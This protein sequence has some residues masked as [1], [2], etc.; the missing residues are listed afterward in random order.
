MVE[1]GISSVR[2]YRERIGRCLSFIQEH[3][4]GELR[5]EDL[6]E[7]ASFSKFH[8]HRVFTAIVGETPAD[9]V[10]RLRLERAANFLATRPSLSI[11]EVAMECGFSSSSVFAREFGRAYG[12]TPSRYRQVGRMPR[13]PGGRGVSN[14]PSGDLAREKGLGDEG[15]VFT[16][17]RLGPYSLA[18]ILH[19]GGYGPSIGASWNRL[20]AWAYARGF[21]EGALRTVGIAWDNPEI[22][23]PP[24]CRYS[25]C[26]EV[27]AGSEGSGEVT[28]LSLP[29][30]SYLATRY[31]GHESGLASAYAHLYHDGLLSS[32]FEPDDAPTI[33]FHNAAPNPAR[34]P[35]FDVTIA[36]PVTPMS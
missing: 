25:V 17:E 3:I 14:L 19:T 2:A 22:T 29:R 16:I 36:V 20:F 13:A 21:A 28:V 9:Y 5:L 6:A 31:R 33:E 7:A 18:Q 15:L 24:K 27:S 26:V 1:A 8:F 10:K 35:L 23:P 32:G 11:T 12:I 30:R 4:R 34:D